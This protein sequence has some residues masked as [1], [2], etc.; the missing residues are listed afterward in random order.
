MNTTL[1]PRFVTV[2]SRY[3]EVKVESIIKTGLRYPG[4]EKI[5]NFDFFYDKGEKIEITFSSD[6]N[7]HTEDCF[8][9]EGTCQYQN[10]IDE[11]DGS[12]DRCGV[13]YGITFT[14]Y[15]IYKFSPYRSLGIE[16]INFTK[17]T[18]IDEMHEKFQKLS[19]K[20]YEICPCYKS[21]TYKDGFCK[22][23]YIRVYT[24]TE[25]EGGD[26]SICMQNE[27]RWI[28][29]NECKHI[30]HSW[31]INKLIDKKCPLCRNN[32]I[33]CTYDPYDV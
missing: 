9:E 26:C 11:K 28:Q 4:T 23:C 22:E 7:W 16:R 2:L 13:Q 20:T 6:K 25:E 30:F 19:G 5:N 8:D 27:G 3:Y 31:C 24:R 12:C 10:P 21:L 14:M 1:T 29:L 33:K 18:T 32:N 17:D 15:I